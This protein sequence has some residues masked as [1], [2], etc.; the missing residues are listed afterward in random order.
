[1]LFH[2]LTDFLDLLVFLV[3]QD[4]LFDHLLGF[5][6]ESLL[7]SFDLLLHFINIGAGAFE[8]SATVDV[9]GFSSSSERALTLS[10]SSINSD[11]RS[12]I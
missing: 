6:D 2:D 11:W 10:F 7:K 12:K 3:D 4:L 5:E 8:V 9:E 1:L